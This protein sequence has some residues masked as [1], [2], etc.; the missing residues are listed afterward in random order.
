MNDFKKEY[1]AV[2]AQMQRA[3]NRCLKSGWYILG[4]ES[5]AFE[6]SFATYVGMKY[7]LGVANGLEALQ[8]SLMALGVR[9][10]DEVL[11][12]SNSAVA[13]SLAITNVGATPVFV[14]VDEY[15]HM[16]L[17]DAE[18]KVTKKTKAILPVHL[19]GQTADLTAIRKFAKKHRLYLVEDACQAHGALYKGKMAG[20]FGELGCFSFYP[21]KN[22]GGY[23][24]GGAITTNSKK[25]YEQC[26]MLR[27]YGQRNRYHHEVKGINSRLDELQAAILNVKLKHLN[28][29]VKKRN[30]IATLYLKELQGIKEIVLP[31]TRPGAYH[32][33]HLFVIQVK[34]REKLM[35]YLHAQGIQSIVH[36]PVPIH[37]QE[38][39]S[40]YNKLKLP[41]TEALAE[42]IVSLPIHPFMTE[43]EVKKVCKHIRTFYGKNK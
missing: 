33:Y 17:A 10:G 18:K 1:K 3:I 6:E 36:Y 7:A 26:K 23:G 5:T 37:K 21:T 35:A 22:L 31:Q 24:D 20:S 42:T 19:F 40:E 34:N 16:D 27:N 29:F 12:V 15:Y 13:T 2:E 4:K 9:S 25:L 8:I 30:Y 14:E 41:V 38:C 28:A 39:Y 43:R 11:T 32:A